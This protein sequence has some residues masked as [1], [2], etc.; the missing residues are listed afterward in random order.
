[1]RQDDQIEGNQTHFE[2]VDIGLDLMTLMTSIFLLR[3]QLYVHGHVPLLS[4]PKRLK[5]CRYYDAAVH[6]YA[7]IG[8]AAC[9]PASSFALALA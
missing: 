5:L 7:S 9:F 6:A 8:S 3:V 4:Y 2:N 1:M